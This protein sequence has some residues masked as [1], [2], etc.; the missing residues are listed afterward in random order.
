MGEWNAN[1]SLIVREALLRFCDELAD[2]SDDEIL[3]FFL[4]ASKTQ[5]ARRRRRLAT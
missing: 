4:D 3:K 1:R 5:V 2:K